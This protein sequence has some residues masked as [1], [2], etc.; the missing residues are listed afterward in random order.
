MFIVLSES[1]A[2]I[3]TRNKEPV[4]QASFDLQEAAVNA[5]TPS[6]RLPSDPLP[7]QDLTSMAI[8]RPTSAG[9]A[10]L[11]ELAQATPAS[12]AHGEAG[13]GASGSAQIRVFHHHVNPVIDVHSHTG[14][15]SP[16]GQHSEQMIVN[17]LPQ[18]RAID[19][20]SP[21]QPIPYPQAQWSQPLRNPLPNRPKPNFDN[22]EFRRPRGQSLAYGLQRIRPSLPIQS[23]GGQAST[24]NMTLYD[25][26]PTSRAPGTNTHVLNMGLAEIQAH[27]QVARDFPGAVGPFPF[28]FAEPL[29]VITPTTPRIP[30]DQQAPRSSSLEPF[31]PFVNIAVQD[32]PRP[33]DSAYNHHAYFARGSGYHA[34]DQHQADPR[35]LPLP[36][37]R[38]GP[39]FTQAPSR[40]MDHQNHYQKQWEPA[41]RDGQGYIPSEAQGNRS[42]HHNP[43]K[44]FSDD[45]RTLPNQ[46]SG[47]RRGSM[48]E[49]YGPAG[50]R[51][52]DQR[53]YRG[54]RRYSSNRGSR[55]NSFSQHGPP[56]RDQHRLFRGPES[57]IGY[58][59]A[60]GGSEYSGPTFERIDEAQLQ[61]SLDHP[62]EEETRRSSIVDRTD[63]VVSPKLGDAD[64]SLRNATNEGRQSEI[65]PQKYR[66]QSSNA[67]ASSLQQRAHRGP[68]DNNS[69]D[70]SW[71]HNNPGPQTYGVNPLSQGSHRGGN[72]AVWDPNKLYV[73]GNWLEHEHV[74]R[75]FSS[76]GSVRAIEGPFFPRRYFG[77][78]TEEKARFFFVR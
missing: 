26:I 45:A 49:N 51:N 18:L 47:S 2:S 72:N 77:N 78:E 13:V 44:N 1:S 73:F 60:V 36:R 41:C 55:Q 34:F 52:G 67:T 5:G 27:E 17:Q 22:I 59:R 29:Q 65:S 31:P 11:D 53:G 28:Q 14:L 56:N 32:L 50:S 38:P 69:N 58:P 10:P 9:D 16:T 20:R 12:A 63:A 7:T 42:Q 6:Q 8:L 76:T 71:Q 54:A 68:S 46:N 57:K 48:D 62:M 64:T 35:G 70:T 74:E 23:L 24:H 39:G 43:R 4:P 61:S 75:M 21:S 66:A 30:L 25:P 3:P 40:G 33:P 37:T 15:M 19:Q